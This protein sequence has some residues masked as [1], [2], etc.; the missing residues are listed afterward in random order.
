M[1]EN[2]QSSSTQSAPVVEQAKTNLPSAVPGETSAGCHS[3]CFSA[4]VTEPLPFIRESDEEFKKSASSQFS[5]KRLLRHWS[6][7]Y[8]I[9]EEGVTG[10]LKLLHDYNVVLDPKD[11][12]KHA[13]NL[14]SVSFK[15]LPKIF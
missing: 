11:L 14:L 9:P 2:E 7:S 8:N 12:P 4:P 3:T 13:K 1:V 6:V 15:I 5:G 10:L